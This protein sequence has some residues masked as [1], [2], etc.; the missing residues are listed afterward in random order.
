MFSF[1]AIENEGSRAGNYCRRRFPV[2][3][4]PIFHDFLCKP[5]PLKLSLIVERSQRVSMHKVKRRRFMTNFHVCMKVHYHEEESL[6][7]SKHNGEQM[8][9]QLHEHKKHP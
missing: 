7:R 5:S 8:R 4:I 6:A 2:N 9:A 3:L 1:K